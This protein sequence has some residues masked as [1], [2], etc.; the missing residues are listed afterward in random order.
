M[1]RRV[2]R[3]SNDAV[4]TRSRSAKDATRKARLVGIAPVRAVLRC[5]R[6]GS[7]I[8]RSKDA[9][10]KARLVGV[11]PVSVV[12]R[13]CWRRDRERPFR[14]RADANATTSATAR[15]VLWGRGLE[16]RL[17]EP[18]LQ[19]TIERSLFAGPQ[20]LLGSDLFDGGHDRLVVR[21]GFLHLR[22]V[23]RVLLI[24]PLCVAEPIQKIVVRCSRARASTIVPEDVRGVARAAA[25]CSIE[26]IRLSP[27]A[28][29]P[30]H[31][32]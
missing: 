20:P 9:A 8:I 13:S 24:L 31:L 7:T 15:R 23:R 4:F 30:K 1:R 18:R 12:V 11:T 2:H 21:R 27:A 6:R 32:H 16:G 26:P 28:K 3:L 29:M 25:R 14:V 10:W 5:L 19:L 22:D 17:L